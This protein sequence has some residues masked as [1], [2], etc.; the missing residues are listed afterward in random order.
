MILDVENLLDSLSEL[1]SKDEQIKLW[2]HGGE[3]QMS[4]YEEAVCGVFDDSRLAEAIDSGELKGKFSS[5]LYALTVKL[6][7]Q[8]RKIPSGLS[9][10][11]IV[12]HPEMDELRSLAGQLRELL[13]R[14]RYR[15]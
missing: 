6:D 13:E 7:S 9:P 3:S 15:V 4:S 1:A 2:V 8:V 5:E 14:E 11:S 10:D 12:N